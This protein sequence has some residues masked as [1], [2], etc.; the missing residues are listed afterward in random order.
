MVEPRRHH[1]VN[2]VVHHIAAVVRGRGH[3]EQLL[4]ARDRRVVDR[5]DVDA[6]LVHQVV[7]EF[8]HEYRVADLVGEQVEWSA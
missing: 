2:E 7:G 8:R 5:L 6:V 1:R 3:S 4:A